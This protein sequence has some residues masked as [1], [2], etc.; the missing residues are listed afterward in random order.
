MD[1]HNE[2]ERILQESE[3]PP[4]KYSTI[5]LCKYPSLRKTTIPLGI[6]FLFFGFLY[7]G[8]S[9]IIDKFSFN[10]FIAQ[11]LL[12]CSDCIAYPTA[13]IFIKNIKRR[14]FSVIGYSV[15]GA[16]FLIGFVAN[17]QG[18]GTFIDVIRMISL[19]SGKFFLCLVTGVLFLHTV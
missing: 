15:V 18:E 6:V 14:K 1:K 8:P 4:K 16:S 10:L 17:T 12:S 11:L 5:D 3:N 9:A 19:F 7:Y 13:S 2:E